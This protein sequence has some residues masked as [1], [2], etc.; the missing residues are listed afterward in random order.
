ML[1][2]KGGQEREGGPQDGTRHLPTR[3]VVVHRVGQGSGGT[4]GADDGKQGRV[5][6]QRPGQRDNRAKT[7]RRSESGQKNV[8]LIDKG[9]R[10]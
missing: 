3:R 6:T 8:A 5:D 7:E 4:H 9:E 1:V 2:G 10:A